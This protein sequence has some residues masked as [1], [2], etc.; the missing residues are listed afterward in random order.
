MKSESAV[1][2]VN[3][4]PR[5]PKVLAAVLAGV[6]SVAVSFSLCAQPCV[7]PP[8][9]LVSW[10]AAEGNTADS[11]G[12]N[13]GTNQGGAPFVAGLVGQAFSFNGVNQCIRVPNSPS[14]NPSGSFSIEAWIYLKAS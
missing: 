10:W 13:N 14:L 11:M 8:S 1:S 7:P 5:H 3:L 9:G 12:V 2:K 6:V 4:Q